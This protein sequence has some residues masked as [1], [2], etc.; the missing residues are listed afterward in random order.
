MIGIRTIPANRLKPGDWIAYRNER[1]NQRVVDVQTTRD[2]F[3]KAHLDYGNGGQ[4][5]TSFFEPEE[6]LNVC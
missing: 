2:G 5:A 1:M 6:S 3:I 4:P